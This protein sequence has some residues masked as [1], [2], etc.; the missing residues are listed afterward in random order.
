MDTAIKENREKV[1]S[2]T[3]HNSTDPRQLAGLHGRVRANLTRT[4]DSLAS[5]KPSLKTGDLPESLSDSS[6][7]KRDVMEIVHRAKQPTLVSMAKAHDANVLS[8]DYKRLYE[9]PMGMIRSLYEQATRE[10]KPSNI[11][12][13]TSSTHRHKPIDLEGGSEYAL[14]TTTSEFCRN[15]RERTSALP[16]SNPI[17]TQP[18]DGTKQRGVQ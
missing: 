1:I 12:C 8:A 3:I 9:M 16:N 15:E 4:G 10:S 7:A 5:F 2:D 13:K 11:I 18:R 6:L 17:C 14:R